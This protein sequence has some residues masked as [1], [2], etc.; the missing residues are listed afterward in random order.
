MPVILITKNSEPFLFIARLDANSSGDSFST[1]K[2]KN[3]VVFKGMLTTWNV[4]RLAHLRQRKFCI[5][6]SLNSGEQ[7]T[8]N[9]ISGEGGGQGGRVPSP[10]VCYKPI[11]NSALSTMASYIFGLCSLCVYKF[12]VAF[13]FTFVAAV[14][15]RPGMTASPLV[16]DRSAPPPPRRH[17][18]ASLSEEVLVHTSNTNTP[19]S[20]VRYAKKTH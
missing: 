2:G 13:S 3:G 4:A 8:L 10:Q 6:L 20:A 19:Q 17:H 16:A 1:C 14:N 5:D 9:I 15:T 7:G 12:S 18:P 11:L